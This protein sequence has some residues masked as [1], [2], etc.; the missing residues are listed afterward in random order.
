MERGRETCLER[1]RKD[2]NTKQYNRCLAGDK[3]KVDLIY[4]NKIRVHQKI[5]ALR[6]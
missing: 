4:E 3:G 1:S 5:V 2:G 6:K